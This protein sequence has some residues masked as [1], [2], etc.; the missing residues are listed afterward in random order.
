M[1][2]L[3]LTVVVGM[4]LILLVFALVIWLLVMNSNRRVSHRL[5][6]A[7][8]DLARH[9]EVMHAEREARQQTMQQIGLELHDNLGQLITVSQLA[10]EQIHM[11]IADTRLEE[12][13][14][15]LEHTLEEVRFLGRSFNVDQWVQRSFPDAVGAE[16]ARLQRAGIDHV[17]FGQE[18]DWPELAPGEKTI[19]FRICQELMTNALKHGGRSDIDVRLVGGPAVTLVVSDQGPGFDP[20]A[21]TVANGLANVQHR[22]GLIGFR[23]ELSTAPGKGCTWRI[24]RA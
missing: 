19:L 12:V 1:T 18:G 22:C 3:G 15:T 6:M 23:A 9:R 4:L 13:V 17:R 16:V 24:I 5:E 8:M 21:A 11:D 14:R 20:H 7:E 10:V 2:E